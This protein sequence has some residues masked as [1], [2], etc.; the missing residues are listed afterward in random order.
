MKRGLKIFIAALLAL[1]MTVPLVSI[2]ANQPTMSELNQRRQ[3]IQGNINEA[4]SN[5]AATQRYLNEAEREIEYLNLRIMDTMED[6]II[7]GY[8][9]D[10]V[11]ERLELATLELEQAREY[12]A[13]QEAFVHTRLREMHEHG[14]LTV[15]DV[16]LQSNSV[17]DFIMR[18]EFMARVSSN[19]QQMLLRLAEAEKRYEESLEDEERL[20]NNLEN[21]FQEMERTAENFALLVDEWEARHAELT[22]THQSFEEMLA[23]YQAQERTVAQQ[24]ANEQR[25]I[26]AENE[27]IRQAQQAQQLANLQ[28]GTNRA[29]PVPGFHRIS[30]DFGPRPNP[31][32]PRVTQFHNGIDIASAGINGANVVA[33]A[34]GR[35]TTASLGWNGGL[36]NVIFIAHGGGYTTVYAHLSQ[37]RVRE[38]QWVYA[39]DTIGNVGSTGSSTGPHLHFEVRRNG[40]RGINPWTF[41]RGS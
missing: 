21:T 11:E 36:G 33:A 35:V 34:D 2:N 16:L 24:I 38:G 12:H 23:E 25:R 7:L 15:F 39:G 31:F 14:Q 10:R 19:D 13:M 4:R 40:A 27:R 1:A 17:R 28:L 20:R 18:L 29:W 3:A 41:L 37:I 30:S 5:I 32:N 6:L 9:M 26:D 8:A 22:I